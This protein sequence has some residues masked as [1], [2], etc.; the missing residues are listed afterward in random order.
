MPILGKA[1]LTS[2]SNPAIKFYR[3]VP[4][5]KKE[6]VAHT[7]QSSTHQTTGRFLFIKKS[8]VSKDACIPTLDNDDLDKIENSWKETVFIYLNR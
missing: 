4:S 1:Q 7:L 2:L 8:F 5:K 3:K 6:F